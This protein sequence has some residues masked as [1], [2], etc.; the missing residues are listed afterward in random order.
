M[1]HSVV[2]ELAD[3]KLYPSSDGKPMGET[4]YHVLSWVLLLQ[5]LEDLTQDVPEVHVAGNMFLY[6]EQGNPKARKAPDAMV[7]ATCCG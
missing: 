4:D 7:R 1:P 5:S 6:Y 3:E 2:D